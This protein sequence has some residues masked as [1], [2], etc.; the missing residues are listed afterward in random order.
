MW[1]TR[2]DITS[3]NHNPTPKF[4]LNIITRKYHTNI[5][6]GTFHKTELDSSKMSTTWETKTDLSNSSRLKK[7]K[8]VWRAYEICDLRLEWS[9]L[10]LLAKIKCRLEWNSYKKHDFD[11]W[12]M[13]NMNTV[14]ILDNSIIWL[15]FLSVLTLVCQIK[16]LIILSG[17]TCSS[18]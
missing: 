11:S 2:K 9:L 6:L 14:C 18:I 10:V 13:L 16:R 1:C 7:N 12:R 3:L 15:S 4:N 8:E 17:D 5:N